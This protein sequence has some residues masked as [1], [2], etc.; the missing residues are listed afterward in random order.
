VVYKTQH[1]YPLL[2]DV[3]HFLHHTNIAEENRSAHARRLCQETRRC[4]IDLHKRA[5]IS[6]QKRMVY[7]HHVLSLFSCRKCKTK[8]GPEAEANASR[9][10]SVHFCN[11]LQL[12][13]VTV[14]TRAIPDMSVTPVVTVTSA[15]DRQFSLVLVSCLVAA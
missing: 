14:Q 6:S 10:N 11:T 8:Q 15:H 3:K 4:R 13:A 5:E 2:A 9:G 12:Q 7:L 1:V